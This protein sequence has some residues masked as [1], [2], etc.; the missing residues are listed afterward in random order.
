MVVDYNATFDRTKYVM[1][2]GGLLAN[3]TYKLTVSGDIE[4]IYG[5]KLGGDHVVEFTT[6]TGY[7]DAKLTGLTQGG[8]AVTNFADLT[9]G[10]ATVTLKYAKTT[11]AEKTIKL[12]YGFY[13]GEKL[14]R[15]TVKDITLQGIETES[16]KSRET[17]TDNVT[18]GDLT[19]ITSVKVMLWEDFVNIKPLCKS[20]DL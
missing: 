1:E 17:I 3:K 16:D 2:I 10:D 9:A 20:I 6:S 15:S 13:N 5:V 18:I 4:N 19:G 12:I 11:T 14:V 7:V 8:N